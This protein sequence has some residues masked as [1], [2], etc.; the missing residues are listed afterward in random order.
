MVQCVKISNF[1]LLLLCS[2]W[3]VATIKTVLDEHR[4]PPIGPHSPL[5]EPDAL[6]GNSVQSS[7][8]QLNAS[9]SVSNSDPLVQVR[10]DSDAFAP[11]Q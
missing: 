9:V 6:V 1:V 8:I 2:M 11:K 4:F 10:P 5:F 7:E 3:H